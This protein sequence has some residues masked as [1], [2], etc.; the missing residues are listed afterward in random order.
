MLSISNT[1]SA[2]N[3]DRESLETPQAQMR[4]RNIREDVTPKKNLE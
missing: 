3:R 4:G 2:I 1:P